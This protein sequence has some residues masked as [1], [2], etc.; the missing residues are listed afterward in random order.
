MTAAGLSIVAV[1]LTGH[2]R[3][4]SFASQP[5]D[6]FAFYM[7]LVFL[8]CFDFFACKQCSECSC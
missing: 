6:C 4:H 1:R 3:P 7:H 5:F 8:L 2:L